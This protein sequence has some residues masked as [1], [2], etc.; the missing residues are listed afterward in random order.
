MVWV[1]IFVGFNEDE[2]EDYCN[3]NYDSKMKLSSGGLHDDYEQRVRGQ[4]T[5]EKM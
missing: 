5:D 3:S 2:P 1:Q 4:V